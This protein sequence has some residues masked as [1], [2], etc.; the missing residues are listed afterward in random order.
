MLKKYTHTNYLNTAV[1]LA[2]GPESNFNNWTDCFQVF[3]QQSVHTAYSI[4]EPHQI[5]W[6]TMIIPGFCYVSQSDNN[7][8]KLDGLLS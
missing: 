4:P 1:F 2:L 3:C 7:L 6:F 5:V 8:D